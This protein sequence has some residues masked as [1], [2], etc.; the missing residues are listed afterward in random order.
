MNMI[1]SDGSELVPTTDV[2][3]TSRYPQ[4]VIK[5]PGH[6]NKNKRVRREGTYFLGSCR[7]FV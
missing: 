1:A 7:Q 2:K 4:N 6:K 3:V 5:V